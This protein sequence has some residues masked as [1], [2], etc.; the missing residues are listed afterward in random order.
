MIVRVSRP[1]HG[2]LHRYSVEFEQIEPARLSPFG[3]VAWRACLVGALGLAVALAAAAVAAP[4]P[5][6]PQVTLFQGVLRPAEAR[7]WMRA[8]AGIPQPE[9]VR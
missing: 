3:R 2:R 7:E 8:P 6:T 4:P 5:V 1:V 9:W